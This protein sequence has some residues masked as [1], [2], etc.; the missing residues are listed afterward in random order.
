MALGE[1][2]LKLYAPNKLTKFEWLNDFNAIR[3]KIDLDKRQRE[4][5]IR[6]TTQSMKLKR[7]IS[8]QTLLSEEEQPGQE[9]V[10]KDPRKRR[11]FLFSPSTVFR[12]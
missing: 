8:Q 4:A 1:T 10:S 11:M 5:A 3:A 7:A 6:N 2:V 12:D 9:D